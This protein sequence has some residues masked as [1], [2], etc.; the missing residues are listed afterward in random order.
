M[1]RKC[2]FKLLFLNCFFVFAFVLGIVDNVNAE[3]TL[4][5]HV[6]FIITNPGEIKGPLVDSD[7]QALWNDMAT[8]YENTG[9]Q[10]TLGRSSVINF[11]WD[12][13]T[14]KK[15]EIVEIHVWFTEYY[16][17]T[18]GTL[19]Y[20]NGGDAEK[21]FGY[22]D[23][24]D[25]EGFTTWVLDDAFDGLDMAKVPS[26]S[27]DGGL[28]FGMQADVL[29]ME[30]DYKKNSSGDVHVQYAMFLIEK[31]NNY[32]FNFK[33]KDDIYYT[34]PKYLDNENYDK[35]IKWI[36]DD[37]SDAID[38]YSS[39]FTRQAWSSFKYGLED[40]PEILV[41]SIV[42]NAINENIPY[43][44]CIDDEVTD[45]LAETSGYEEIGGQ[46]KKNV[47][48]ILK[49]VGAINELQKNMQFKK[50]KATDKLELTTKE[51]YIKILAK[52]KYYDEKSARE[53]MNGVED[54]YPKINKKFKDLKLA[55]TVGDM[56]ISM[57]EID[58]IQKEVIDIMIHSIPSDT[59]L[60]DSLKRIE[61]RANNKD[62]AAY[63]VLSD[64]IFGEIAD[65]ISEDVTYMTASAVA[66]V[67]YEGS[68]PAHFFGSLVVKGWAWCIV[69]SS[70]D[71]LVKANMDC[72]TFILL[73][74]AVHKKYSEIDIA[75]KEGK[76]QSE[77]KQ[78]KNEYTILY[79]AHLNAL[80]K[81]VGQ[82][83]SLTSPKLIGKV[84]YFGWNG[85]EVPILTSSVL[86]RHYNKLGYCE[87]AIKMLS[88]EGYINN[89]FNNCS[90]VVGSEYQFSFGG[91][92]GG[93]R[94][95]GYNLSKNKI[96]TSSLNSYLAPAEDGEFHTQAYAEVIFV[97]DQ[98]NGQ[99]VVA[100]EDGAFGDELTNCI[101]VI[102]DTITEIGENAFSDNDNLIIGTDS[103]GLA[104]LK[105][106]QTSNSIVTVEKKV[107]SIEIVNFPT[108]TD[109]IGNEELDEKGM[110]LKVV[111]NN[112]TEKE[113]TSGW[114]SAIE[115]RMIGE[116]V[117]T[118]EYGGATVDYSVN[119]MAGEVE[120]MVKYLDEN[121][122]ELLDTDICKG[123]L[124]NTV[125]INAKDIEYYTANIQ[126]QSIKLSGD[127]VVI[128]N[129]TKDSTV[130]ISDTNVEIE[131]K[132]KYTGKEVIPDM[133][134]AYNGIELQKDKDY[135]VEYGS[136]IEPGTAE[137]LIWGI[138]KFS[139]SKLKTY[140]IA[141]G[142]T[143]NDNK[144]DN[145]NLDEKDSSSDKNIEN[146]RVDDEKNGS[147]VTTDTQE[148]NINE[149]Q[150]DSGI[151]SSLG[152]VLIDSSGKSKYKIISDGTASYLLQT[153][154]N[155]KTVTIPDDVVLNGVTYTVTEIAPN[156]FKNCKKLTKVTIGKNIIKIGKNAF[157]GCKNLKTITI[158]STKLTKKSFGKNAFK[159]ISKKATITVP[160]KQY[161]NYKKWLKA[162]G[163]PK[164]VKIKKK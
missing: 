35:I 148:R 20:S 50:N 8:E 70:A 117:V 158:K 81:L 128:F 32:V 9:D 147:G 103:E 140:E 40:G 15:D 36:Y 97:P 86:K 38:E 126:T 120:Y 64:F 164:G 17:N 31:S 143:G 25:T 109:Y 42:G 130:D 101:F 153:N 66:D 78:L 160:K 116:N 39:S 154:K 90:K 27:L 145:Q 4:D 5:E 28:G 55:F 99:P 49:D 26:S 96:D 137:V 62:V 71:H 23:I 121:G 37:C 119:V 113:I 63:S 77:L 102:P 124:G 131:D 2:F 65:L 115:S 105:E 67:L 123:T 76:S 159:G 163:L 135:E 12:K 89:C 152:T 83:R 47:D 139:G 112:E 13:S 51:N 73:S 33:T 58:C 43:R 21:D 92:G 118:V 157:S 134:I 110:V 155:I 80:K 69:G 84:D 141:R 48:Q 138:G 127:T 132:V 30:I 16:R 122:N 7:A 18:K 61:K 10:E 91:G 74:R 87:E 45:I 19:E 106:K 60:Y 56:A 52:T 72:S 150:N 29:W 149:E 108:R 57:I 22:T 41:K 111:Y 44:N 53:L 54:N 146:D 95:V 161:K 144:E 94:I 68:T 79:V 24:G 34:Y 6:D 59:D 1:N 136:N 156:A 3:T 75:V 133:T 142:D 162:S 125:T 46:A 104:I 82:C 129:Y 93:T 11:D 85:V 114:N 100:I 98:V 107:E 151:E 88:Y 14:I